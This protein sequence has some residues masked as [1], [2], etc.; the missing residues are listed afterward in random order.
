MIEKSQMRAIREF[1]RATRLYD[2]RAAQ[3]SRCEISE[4]NR[5]GKGDD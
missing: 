1:T 5:E 2:R 4:V 3:N